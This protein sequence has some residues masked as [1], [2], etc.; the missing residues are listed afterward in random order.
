MSEQYLIQALLPCK[1]GDGSA[2]EVSTF[3]RI[4][5]ELT[6]RFGGITAYTRAG[7]EGRWK[8]GDGQ[9]CNDDVI[10]VEIVAKDLDWSWWSGFR[11]R[12]EHE[13]DQEEILIRAHPIQLI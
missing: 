6:E 4:C 8:D 9:V 10:A 11:E 7:A 1:R 12:L 2:M 3:E 13:L 5:A